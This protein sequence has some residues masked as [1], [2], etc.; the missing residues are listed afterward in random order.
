M[1]PIIWVLYV[2]TRHME[3]DTVAD[4][5]QVTP[6]SDDATTTPVSD[7]APT[8]VGADAG[9]DALWIA[10]PKVLFSRLPI[11]G[12][13]RAQTAAQANGAAIARRGTH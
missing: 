10:W 1:V 5:Q 12:G 9:T 8:C 2:I 4:Q 7:D 13:S 3:D 6:V 11:Q